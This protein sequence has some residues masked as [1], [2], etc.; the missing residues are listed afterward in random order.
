MQDIDLG[1]DDFGRARLKL[2]GASAEIDL[3]EAQEVIAR[4]HQLA[5]KSGQYVASDFIN[6]VRDWLEKKGLPGASGGHIYKLAEAVATITEADQ[7][8]TPT[9]ASASSP[10]S[11]ESTPSGLAPEPSTLS[12]PT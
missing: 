1:D 12:G 4:A 7:K 10:A 8:K 2:G 9:A 11:T 5:R 6:H 3:Y